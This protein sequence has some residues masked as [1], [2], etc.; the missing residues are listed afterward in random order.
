MILERGRVSDMEPQT[1]LDIPIELPSREEI[2]AN[3]TCKTHSV[4]PSTL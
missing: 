4:S 2:L 3:F 1:S